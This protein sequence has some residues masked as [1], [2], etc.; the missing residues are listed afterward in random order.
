MRNLLMRDGPRQSQ[1][2]QFYGGLQY[3]SRSGRF[4]L[5]EEYKRKHGVISKASPVQQA[6]QCLAFEQY[7]TPGYQ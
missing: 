7:L 5:F 2:K 6:E 3:D 1:R 4:E